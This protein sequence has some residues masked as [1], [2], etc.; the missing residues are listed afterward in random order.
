MI[1]TSKPVIASSSAFCCCAPFLVGELA[2]VTTLTGG[3]D[4][5]VQPLRADRPHL[6]GHLGTH[7]VTGGASRPAA[8]RWPAPADPATPT[9]STS[10]LAGFTVPAAVVNIGKNR[11]DSDAATSTALYPGDVGLRRQRVHHLRARD[12]RDRLQ[13]ERLHTGLLQRVDLVVGV[14]RRQE[15]RSA[16]ARCLSLATSS[17]VGGATL[18]H[19]IGRPRVADRRAR[20]GI[21]VIG[22]QRRLAGAGLDDD[23]DT[24]LLTSVATA[25]GTSATRA[26]RPTPGLPDHPDS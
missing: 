12:P 10:T 18:H 17:A 20:L 22:Q 4:A 2:G 24:P 9:P 19:Y 11:V 8:W 7:V 1:T 16:S 13:R 14:A 23:R 6:V 15:A 25:F 21:E 3:L 5:E 26:V